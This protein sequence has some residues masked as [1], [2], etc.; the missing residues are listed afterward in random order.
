M[1]DFKF[2]FRN[3]LREI[4]A[5]LSICIC[6]QLTR[7]NQKSYLTAHANF[8]IMVCMQAYLLNIVQSHQ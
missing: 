3:I 7:F 2:T 5:T 8:I 1:F 6:V 4:V